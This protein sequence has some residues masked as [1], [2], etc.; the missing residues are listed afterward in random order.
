MFHLNK[1]IFTLVAMQVSSLSVNVGL[2]YKRLGHP[3]SHALKC[4]LK[5]CNPSADVNEIHKLIFCN[6]CQYGKNHLQHFNSIDTETTEP[7]QLLYI[8]L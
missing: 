7:L 4:V 2:L 1:D 8:D 5:S 6:A 3:A